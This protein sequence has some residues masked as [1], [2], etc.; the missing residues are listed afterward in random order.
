MHGGQSIT[1]VS[2]VLQPWQAELL[3]DE[4]RNSLVI[5][6]TDYEKQQQSPDLSM[7]GS[8]LCKSSSPL[9][10]RLILSHL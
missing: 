2:F 10:L 4:N 3:L 6:V 9:L 5:S 7:M 8:I 1:Q